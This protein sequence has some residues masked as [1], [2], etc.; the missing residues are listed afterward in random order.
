MVKLVGFFRAR[1]G[2]SRAEFRRYYE[3]H[4]AHLIASLFG[5]FLTDYR[6]SYVQPSSVFAPNAAPAPTVL[7]FDVVVEMWFGTVE[8]FQRSTEV[9]ARP[10]VAELIARDEE[11][12]LDRTSMV[13]LLVDEWGTAVFNSALPAE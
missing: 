5:E 13:N 12:F 10:E 4:H 7:D 3:D 1:E 9:A 8:S 11:I 6:R 2:M